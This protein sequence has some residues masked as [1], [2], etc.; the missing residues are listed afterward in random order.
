[1]FLII[2]QP[3]LLWRRSN[4]NSMISVFYYDIFLVLLKQ[5]NLSAGLLLF[6]TDREWRLAYRVLAWSKFSSRTQSI[7]ISCT[8]KSSWIWLI[9]V[10]SFCNSI[11]FFIHNLSQ[12]HLYTHSVPNLLAHL[13]KSIKQHN[14][15][16]HSG[17]TFQ[18]KHHIKLS[19]QN[20]EISHLSDM[21]QDIVLCAR[22]VR[23]SIS[24]LVWKTGT[25]H[26]IFD[27]QKS[28][29]SMSTIEPAGLHQQ[30]TR[31]AFCSQR[32]EFEV[33]VGTFLLKLDKSFLSIHYLYH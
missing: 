13:D 9:F 16:K 8:M 21:D 31:A 11:C 28:I 17:Y 23:L 6:F 3:S 12:P 32:Y 19:D 22:W 24:R 1:M 29:S 26:Y 20:V 14:A 33:S 2:P 25:P 7:V 4:G 18:L 27:E 30:N 5:S 10:L 15:W